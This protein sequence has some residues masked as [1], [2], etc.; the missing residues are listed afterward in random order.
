LEHVLGVVKEVCMAR[1]FDE[2]LRL[3][4]D[5]LGA[6][7]REAERLGYKCDGPGGFVCGLHTLL[8][9]VID[10]GGEPFPHP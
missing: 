3:W 2:G 5:W 1:E 9:E 10:G 4:L 6:A 8:K 7:H